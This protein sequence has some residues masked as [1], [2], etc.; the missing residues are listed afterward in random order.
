MRRDQLANAERRPRHPIVPTGIRALA[1][2]SPRRSRPATAPHNDQGEAGP[3]RLSQQSLPSRA[4]RRK[5][6]TDRLDDADG[7]SISKRDH[8]TGLRFRDTPRAGSLSSE[9]YVRETLVVRGEYEYEQA[10]GYF[11]I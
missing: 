1:L 9:A 4:Y 10:S 8:L 2:A 6:H 11:Q 3:F 5:S 7:V